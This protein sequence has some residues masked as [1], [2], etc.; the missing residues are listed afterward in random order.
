MPPSRLTEGMS[1]LHTGIVAGVAPGAALAGVVID[2]SGA[3]RGLLR[4]GRRRLLAAL[5]ALALPRT[6]ARATGR[7]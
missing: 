7:S 4:L 1:F 5:A 3:V 6:T 2:R